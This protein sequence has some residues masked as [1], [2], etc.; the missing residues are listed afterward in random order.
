MYGLLLLNFIVPYVMIFVGHTLKKHPASDMKSQNG[1]NTPTSRKSQSHWDYAQNIAPDI[2][3]SIGKILGIIEII[4]SVLM[5]L[6]RASYQVA[7]IAGGCVGV[8]FLLFGFYK[9]DSEIEKK[10]IEN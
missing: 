7:L 8:G 3:I 6:V 2:F 1:Y 5:L 10:F 9:T 4:L